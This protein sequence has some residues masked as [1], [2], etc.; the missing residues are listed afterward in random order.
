M[1]LIRP[2]IRNID[3]NGEIEA[4]ANGDICL[5]LGYN[6]DVVQARKRAAEAKNGVQIAYVIPDGGS[7]YWID[8]LAIPRDA[9]H[10]E[11]AYRLINY[12]LDAKVMAHISNAIGFANGNAAST[13]LLDAAVL[14]D[15][16]IYPAA[17]TQQRLL[18]P[19]EVTPEQSRAITRLWQ[20]FKTGQ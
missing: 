14:S 8:T 3:S 6:G 2:S 12:L 10:P 19:W 11:N 4:L 1:I 9:P 13:P 15:P 16:V 5:T 20:K 7:T 18:P 17:D